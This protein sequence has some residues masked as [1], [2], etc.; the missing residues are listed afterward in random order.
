M[1]TADDIKA[2]ILAQGERIRDMKKNPDTKDKVGP[3]VEKLLA[4]KT[5]YKEVTG[6]EY[7]APGQGKQQKKEKKK[8]PEQP[9]QKKEG[10]SKK[11]LKKLERKANKAT[12][13]AEAKAG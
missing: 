6:E 9:K 12:K 1:A 2:E 10:P 3:E 8:Q 4:L 11:D 7:V 13:K 5:Q